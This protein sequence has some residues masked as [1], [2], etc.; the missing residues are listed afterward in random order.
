MIFSE[1]SQCLTRPVFLQRCLRTGWISEVYK[2]VSKHR[3]EE[4][5]HCPHL[6]L[7]PPILLDFKNWN[8]K[9]ISQH[10]SR[11]TATLKDPRQ[12]EEKDL[13]QRSHQFH[14]GFT[15]KTLCPREHCFLSA[16]FGYCLFVWLFGW[17]VCW[18]LEVWFYNPISHPIHILH[19]II[20]TKTNLLH[21]FKIFY[22]NAELEKRR[23]SWKRKRSF[24][25]WFAVQMG[26]ASRAEHMWSL[27]PKASSGS[28]T[29]V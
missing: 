23:D 7:S 21:P 27:E 14:F 13:Q 15:W 10:Y 2:V 11:I 5:E 18:L 19:F 29:C 6:A 24:N 3:Q 12:K 1:V 17:L 20:C 9:L 22:W 16:C 25:H 28:P 4:L 8:L 26:T